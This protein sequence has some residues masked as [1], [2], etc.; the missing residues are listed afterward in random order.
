M[1]PT[2]DSSEN[3]PTLDPEAK[4]RILNDVAAFL[5]LGEKEPTTTPPPAGATDEPTT[6]G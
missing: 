5:K 4:E 2:N 1:T 3:F 6:A